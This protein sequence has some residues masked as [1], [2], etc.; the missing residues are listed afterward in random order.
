MERELLPESLRNKISP[1][2]SL[3]EAVSDMVAVYND[4]ESEFYK[5]DARVHVMTSAGLIV[6]EFGTLDNPDNGAARVLDTQRIRIL[7][8]LQKQTEDPLE[9]I[10]KSASYVLLHKVVLKPW[11]DLKSTVNFDTLS[12]FVDDILAFSIGSNPF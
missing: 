2:H 12:V 9:Y 10:G 1:R 8:E 6:A 7:Q 4:P 5:G 11:G 3:L